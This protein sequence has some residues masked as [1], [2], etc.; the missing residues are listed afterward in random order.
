MRADTIL[1]LLMIKIS[2]NL[3]AGRLRPDPERFC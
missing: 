3:P 1:E 2:A